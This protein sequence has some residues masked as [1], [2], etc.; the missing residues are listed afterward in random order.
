[1]KQILS[2]WTE[3]KAPQQL[4]VGDIR[5]FLC[6][7]KKFN[8]CS[9][10]EQLTGLNIHDFESKVLRSNISIQHADLHGMNILL[11]ESNSPIVIDY[12]DI[13]SCSSVIDPI[14]LELSHYFHP[15]MCHKIERNLELASQWF[16]DDAIFLFNSNP[17][18]ALFL[19][20]WSRDNSFLRSDYI[21]GVYAY[22]MRQLTYD[23]I[24]KDFAK[25]L[26]K[27]AINE[28]N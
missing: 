19:R 28:F 21:A 1:M 9:L 3:L 16:N 11:S 14:T 2:N 24:D 20:K 8:D 22:A 18:T 17:T 13:K 15:K 23:D 12:G 4:S 26:I 6:S 27:A 5:R 10:A 7:D 25:A